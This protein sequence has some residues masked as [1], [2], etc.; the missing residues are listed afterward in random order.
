MATAPDALGHAARMDAIYRGQRHIYD[1]TR[2]YYLLGRDR[3]IEELDCQP[4]MTVLEI[5]CG[6][7][8]NLV[9]IAQRWP[10]VRLY[11]LDISREMLASAQAALLRARIGEPA[12]LA[13]GDATLFDSQ[14]L[15]G[16]ARFDRI[17]FSFTLSMM[18]GWEQALEQACA[19]L[20][21]GGRIAMVDFGRQDRL[22]PLFARALHAWLRRFHVTPRADLPVVI[23]A[24]AREHG[25]IARSRQLYRGYSWIGTLTDA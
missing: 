10:R 7:G 12:L 22:P 1:L 17:V 19:L 21:P 3:L 23:D 14:A 5:G 20:A 13:R 16:R 24:L 11:G 9:R 25:L 2:K 15:F 4:G 18:P 8:R 6:T